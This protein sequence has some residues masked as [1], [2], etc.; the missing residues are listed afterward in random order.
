[1]ANIIGILILTLM[2][3]VQS[4][5]GEKILA[6]FPSDVKSHFTLGKVVL[7]ELANR[8]HEVCAYSTFVYI[9]IECILLQITFFSQFTLREKH[10]NITEVR[11]AGAKESLASKGL[12]EENHLTARYERSKI[13]SL[14][15]LINRATALVDYT[16]DYPVL[17][18][19]LQNKDEYDLL[20][21]DMYLTDALLG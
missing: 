14:T 10:E 3:V 8:G 18:D 20:I 6:V 16:L 21:I 12:E 5:T 7:T 13:D 2:T 11:L 9:E 19:I 17:L 15:N 1:M 4:I